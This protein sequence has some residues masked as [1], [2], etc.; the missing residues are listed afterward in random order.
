MRK[1]NIPQSFWKTSYAIQITGII[2]YHIIYI[3]LILVILEK[4]LFSYL[5]YVV[6]LFKKV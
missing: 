3:F 4:E 6:K 5:H 1:T 2:L